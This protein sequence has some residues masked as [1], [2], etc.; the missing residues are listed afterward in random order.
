[1]EISPIE[2]F[3]MLVYALCFGMLCGALNDLNRFARALMGV[4]YGAGNYERLYSIKLPIYRKTL[5]RIKENKIQKI[6]LNVTVFF[7]DVF[8]LLYAGCG[9]AIIN[10]Y[11][12]SGRVRIYAPISAAMGFLVYFFTVG[13]ITSYLFEP[14]VFVIR[15]LFCVILAIFYRPTR[16]FVVF[17]VKNIKKTCK[18]IY[19]TIAKK[20][21]KVYNNKK[22]ISVI[23]KASLGFIDLRKDKH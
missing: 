8:L 17:L 23:K 18:N 20:Q 12:N 21:K 10:Y 13:R 7:Q 2:I 11:F 6:I 19:K 1:M 9:V 4:R 16:F 14:I 5:E 15:G 22:E 3:R